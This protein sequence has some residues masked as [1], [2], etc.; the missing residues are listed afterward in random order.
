M[1]DANSA[2]LDQ[3]LNSYEDRRPEACDSEEEFTDWETDP[4]WEAHR[5]SSHIPNDETRREIEAARRGEGLI[6]A[7]DLEDL[8]QKL[9]SEEE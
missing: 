5:K 4:A 7:K 6:P 8:L 3:S 1:Q 9:Y 2:A